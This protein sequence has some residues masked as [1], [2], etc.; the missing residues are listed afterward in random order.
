MDGPGPA[1]GGQIKHDVEGELQLTYQRSANCSLLR[2][3]ENR[4]LLTEF[5]LIFSRNNSKF[6]SLSRPRKIQAESNGSESPNR[7]RAQLAGD[8]LV[9][10]AAEIFNGEVGD[11]RIGPHSR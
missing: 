11:I 4:Q 9:I 1:A 3:K 10:M 5:A 2:Q 8:P 6:D 7:K